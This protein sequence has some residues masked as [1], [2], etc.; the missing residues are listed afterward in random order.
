[1]INNSSRLGDGGS[2]SADRS[3]VKSEG[4]RRCRDTRPP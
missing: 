1:M 3:S 2:T 4:Y